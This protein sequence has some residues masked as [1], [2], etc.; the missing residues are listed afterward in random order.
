[1]QA[2]L[3]SHIHVF[4]YRVVQTFL[5]SGTPLSRLEWF[6]PL[7]ERANLPLASANHLASTYI[8]RVEEREFAHLKAELADKF[9]G[10]AFDGTSRLGEAVNV[11]ARYCSSDFHIHTRLVRF[12]TAHVHLNATGFASIITR[13][14]CTELG[15]PPENVACLSRDSVLV[16][17]AACGLLIQNPFTCAEN[18]M[19]ISHTLNNV[20]SRIKFGTLREFMTPWLELVGGTHPHQGAKA[21]WRAAVLRPVPGYSSTRWYSLAEIQFVLAENFNQLKP[22]LQTLDQLGYGD[23]TRKK[24]HALLDDVASYNKL[25]LQLAAMLDMKVLVKTTYELEGDRLELLLVYNR[26]E[27][28]RELGRALRNGADGVLP[29]VDATLRANATL[30]N[31]VMLEKVSLMRPA[32]H[33][34]P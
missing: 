18:Q 13:V 30:Q 32:S 16:N 21:L 9:I 25:R 24:L 4:R 7:L 11:T 1:M 29:N 14:M 10:I 6:R 28:L 26:I 8:P 20:G 22:F 23:T 3:A 17:G 5:I 2:N 27:K 34:C 33:T 15:I 19:C 12:L 31:G